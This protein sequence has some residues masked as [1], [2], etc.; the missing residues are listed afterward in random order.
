MT[1]RT[2]LKDETVAVDTIPNGQMAASAPAPVEITRPA[3]T[4]SAGSAPA[5]GPAI[6]RRDNLLG[7][8]AQ[9]QVHSFLAQ[10]GWKF[11]WKSHPKRDAY[12]FWHKHFAGVFLPEHPDKVDANIHDCAGE[13]Q[14]K[15]PILYNFWQGLHAGLLKRHR[16]VRC[17]ANAFA[18]G[19]DGS[20]H[21]DATSPKN[22]TSIWYAN[23]QWNA[24]WGGETVF[25]NTERTDIV[26][27]VYPQPNR[28]VM[29]PG[30][31]PHVARGVAR[32]CPDLR[33]TLMFKTE[34]DQ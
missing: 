3:P 24:D 12:S 21:V 32:S 1:T 10:P 13:L 5:T 29:F 28:L 23:L 2:V 31:I 4:G 25:F 6:A 15:A 16:L 26:A 34:I 7:P 27:A 8:D 19:C 33:I 18:Y 30:T 9:R 14:D 22:F 17:Y 11:G 20:L